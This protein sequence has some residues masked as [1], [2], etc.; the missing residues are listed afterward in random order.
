MSRLIGVLMHF[1]YWLI[2]G[3]VNPIN[4]DSALKKQMYLSMFEILEYFSL[5][6]DNKHTWLTLTMPMI[7]LTLKMMADHLLKE[8][9]PI[10]FG[11]N[12]F[13]INPIGNVATDKLLYLIQNIFD[14]SNL[15]GRFVFLES[16]F[17]ERQSLSHDRKN[18]RRRIYGT[19]PMIN[20]IIPHPKDGKSR[21]IMAKKHQIECRDKIF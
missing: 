3:N 1:S 14:S 8:V 10:F 12:S 4:I 6:H 5:S 2:F 19:S 9:Y 13:D 17:N 20:M 11:E 7:L 18:I 16:V 15:N 21:A